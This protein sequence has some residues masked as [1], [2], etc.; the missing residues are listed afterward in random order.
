MHLPTFC[1]SRA[2]TDKCELALLVAF[3]AAMIGRVRRIDC[4]S[5][6]F[7]CRALFQMFLLAGLRFSA[8]D[9]I[10]PFA[11]C[12]LIF[13]DYNTRFPSISPS[14]HGF[15]KRWAT[16]QRLVGVSNPYL[17]SKRHKELFR[18][19][20]SGGLVLAPSFSLLSICFMAFKKF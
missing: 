12:C 16:I 9:A 4:D 14:C 11:T 17:F 1:H 5:S 3:G 2:H 15:L 6:P 19:A 8:C 7:C 20:S 18:P 13:F 10:W